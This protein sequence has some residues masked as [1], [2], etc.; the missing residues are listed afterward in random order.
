MTDR[1]VTVDGFDDYNMTITHRVETVTRR[2]PSRALR[3]LPADLRGVAN[4]YG[5]LIERIAAGGAAPGFCEGGGGG[6]GQRE[7]SQSV[8]TEDVACCAVPGAWW[9]PV[10]CAWPA[11]APRW[12]IGF[13]WSMSSVVGR[14]RR[15]ARRMG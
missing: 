13:W 14:W 4:A 8:M 11:M 6:G 3:A 7:G 5:A 10:R 1:V 9:A 15:C 2:L 12:P